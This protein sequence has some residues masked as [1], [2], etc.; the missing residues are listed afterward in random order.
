MARSRDNE[1][2]T[3]ISS[4]PSFKTPSPEDVSEAVRKLL[5]G[6]EQRN[7]DLMATVHNEILDILIKSKL[8]LPYLSIMLNMLLKE[9]VDRALVTYEYT[10]KQE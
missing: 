10:V 1:K 7:R 9:V 6:Y 5:D 2:A 8:T 4:A 3:S